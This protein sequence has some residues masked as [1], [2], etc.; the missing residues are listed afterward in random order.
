MCN[1]ERKSQTSITEVRCKNKVSGI[2]TL[3]LLIPSSW[4]F[5]HEG[6][7]DRRG[8]HTNS[9]GTNYHCHPERVETT[10]KGLSRVSGDVTP[11]DPSPP[12]MTVPDSSV[13]IEDLMRRV[14]ALENQTSVPIMQQVS[15]F[16]DEKA[17][18]AFVFSYLGIG[19]SALAGAAIAASNENVGGSAAYVLFPSL[20]GGLWTSSVFALQ[21]GLN[22]DTKTL[23]VVMVTL[24]IALPLITGAL[25]AAY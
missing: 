21:T 2:L 13:Q 8:C 5:A 22:S 16:N 19:V 4:V 10:S 24:Q 14:R 1:K 18:Q 25:L 15:A 12:S 20:V 17:M 9:D 23:G 6:L 7:L 11:E 3:L